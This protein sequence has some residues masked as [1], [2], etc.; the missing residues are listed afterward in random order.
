MGANVAAS[1]RDTLLEALR[2]SKAER[3]VL[4]EENRRLREQ[5][6][7]EQGPR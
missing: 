4:L 3:E 5:L 2:K 6:L 1:G 7:E